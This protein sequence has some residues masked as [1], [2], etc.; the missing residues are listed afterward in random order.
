MEESF[1]IRLSQTSAT[2]SMQERADAPPPAPT[3]F[4]RVDDLMRI[5][6]AE[7]PVEWYSSCWI[8]GI[9]MRP[10]TTDDVRFPTL[11]VCP[12]LYEALELRSRLLEQGGAFVDIGAP[13]G[14]YRE[15]LKA[16]AT[17]EGRY[18]LQTGEPAAYGHVVLEL[19]PEAAVAGVIVEIHLDTD[20]I[21]QDFWSAI[22]SALREA[23]VRGGPA[24]YPLTGLRV[25]VIGG[26]VHPVDSNERAYRYATLLAMRNALHLQELHL[27]ELEQHGHT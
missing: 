20:T 4:F 15:R 19:I 18:V 7:T 10:K 16:P 3:S 24:G 11:V 22:V 8:H 17:G 1:L 2:F 14:G 9:F 26:S 23:V 12:T 25:K 5:A 27:L 21:P 6:T 13:R